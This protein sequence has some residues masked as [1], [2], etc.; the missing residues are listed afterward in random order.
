MKKEMRGAKLKN[1][2]QSWV[3]GTIGVQTW[4]DELS[5]SRQLAKQFAANGWIEKIGTGAYKMV[6]DKISWLGAIYTLQTIKLYKIH[7]GSI[8]ALDL[9][10]YSQ[11][12]SFG[13]IQPKWILKIY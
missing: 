6:G 4:L 1:L 5:I 10:G 9:S 8:T 7:V 3:R 13:G 2:L 12:L 11:Y